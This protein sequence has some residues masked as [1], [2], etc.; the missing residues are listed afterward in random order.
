MESV[1]LACAI[2]DD[3]KIVKFI[4]LKTPSISLFTL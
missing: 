3:C 1:R 4:T 2:N